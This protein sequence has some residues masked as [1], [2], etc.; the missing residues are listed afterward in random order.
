[1]QNR[2]YAKIISHYIETDLRP[3]TAQAPLDENQ[4]KIWVAPTGN[5][6]DTTSD[7]P[8][9][10]EPSFFWSVDRSTSRQ[11][12]KRLKLT[13]VFD[14]VSVSPTLC[15]TFS[16]FSNFVSPGSFSIL[17]HLI[18]LRLLWSILNSKR[19]EPYFRLSFSVQKSD[20]R[21]TGAETNQTVITV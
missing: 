6:S 7:K 8:P 14:T 1:M 11:P 16:N 15:P 9:T 21:T 2:S 4:T 19:V 12:E 10:D 13:S 18:K 20:Y 17:P 5:P 3:E